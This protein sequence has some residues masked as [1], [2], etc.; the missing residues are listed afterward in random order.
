MEREKILFTSESVTEGHPDKMCDQISDAILD[1]LMKQDPMSRV[2][3]ETCCTT[4]VVMVMGEITTKAY[5]DIPKIVRDTVREIGYTRGKYGFDADTC[6]VITTIDEQSSDIAMG[7]DKALEAK[8]NKMS[9]DDIE[10]IGA[11]D[12][13]MMFGYATNETEEYM[14]Y[15]ISL[16]HKLALQLTKVRKDGTLSYLRPD[17]KTQVSVE[18]DENDRPV[19]LEA[20]V[21]STQ[22]APE[23]SQEQIHEDIKKYVFDVILPKDMVDENTKFFINPTGR[24]VIGGPHGDSGLTGRKIIVDTYGGYARH[25]GG[26]FSGKDCT[27]VDRSAAY[28]ARYAAKNIVASGLAEKCEIQLSYA[29]GVAKPTSIMVDTF[30]TGKISDEKITEIVRENFDFRPAGIIKMLDLRRPIYRQTASYGH[31]GRND[32]ELPWERLDKAKVLKKYMNRQ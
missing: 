23:V 7:V 9:E 22:H 10:A 14:P 32:L 28:A 29:I 20:V 5:V 19:R 16:A 17:G 24:F 8:E 2:A 11:G 30:G 21:L 31:F 6:G 12:Q 25:G 18:Y 1:E 3:C 26:A 27:K 15:P 13:G 4:G